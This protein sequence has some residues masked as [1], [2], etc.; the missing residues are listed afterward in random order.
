MMNKC[1]GIMFAVILGLVLPAMVI[2]MFSGQSAKNARE[3]TTAA[4][5]P[6]DGDTRQQIAVMMDDGSIEKMDLENYLICVVLREMPASFETEALKAQSVVARTYA[7]RRCNG[8]EK[9]VEAAVCTDANCC[10]G[11][12]TAEQYIADGGS[13]ESVEKVKSAVEATEALVLIYN[14]TLIDAT[15]FSCSGGKTEDAKAVWGAEVPYLKSVDSPGEE[16]V[17]R[18]VDT[19]TFD[20]EEFASLLGIQLAEKEQ[21]TIGKITYTNGGGV[22]TIKV[23]DKTFNGTQFRKKLSLRSTAFLISVVGQTVSVTTKGFGHRVGMSQYGADAMAVCGATFPQ[24]LAH[25]YTGTQLV[26]YHT[27]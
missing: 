10:Q 26:N 18:Y 8:G 24:I 5:K 7:L 2:N 12:C 11:Y 27:D 20:K 1:K 15:Y 9:H 19:V 3:P 6:D 21:V 23:C 16:N 25:Y 22:D 4:T 17:D 13:Q 14:G